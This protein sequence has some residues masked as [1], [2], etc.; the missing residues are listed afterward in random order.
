MPPALYAFNSSYLNGLR[1]R[2]PAIEAHFVDHFTPILFRTLRRKVRSADQIR[3]V[4][5]ETFLRVLAAIRSGREVRKPERF[6]V[7]VIGVC[8][9][10]V[11][12]TYREQCRLIALE[13]LETEAVAD[14]PSPY[15]LIQAQETGQGVHRTLSELNAN[16]RDILKATLLDEQNAEEICRRLGVTKSY[17]RVLICRAKKRYRIRAGKGASELRNRFQR[18]PLEQLQVQK[19]D[20]SEF[21]SRV[22]ID[23]RQLFTELVAQS[24]HC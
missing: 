13:P 2:D 8:N 3:D 15:T 23:Q 18:G 9:N 22:A 20:R 4:R 24:S 12:E 11:R 6:E 17:L 14:V 10:I 5:Q 1:Q 7:F 21:K 16:D 19:Q